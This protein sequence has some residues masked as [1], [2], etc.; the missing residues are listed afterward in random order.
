[1]QRVGLERKSYSSV[2]VP[3]R[4]SHLQQGLL[5]DHRVAGALKMTVNL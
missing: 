4:E 2:L 3:W 1:M 5:A